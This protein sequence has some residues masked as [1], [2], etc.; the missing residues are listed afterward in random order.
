VILRHVLGSLLIFV[1]SVLPCVGQTRPNAMAAFSIAGSVRDDTGQH[2]M[3]NIRVDLKQATGIPVNT[4]FTRG[5]GRFEFAGLSNGEYVVE[6]VVKDYEPVQEKVTISGLGRRD[7]NIF[8]T[9]PKTEVDSNFGATISVHE[10]SVPSKAHEEYLKGLN[11]MYGKLDYTGAIVQFQR[12]IKDFPSFY[13]AYAQE[14]NAYLR[15]GE[16]ASAEESMR[17]SVNLSSGHYSKA[18][19]MLAAVLNETKRYSEAVTFARQGMAIDNG[20]WQGPLELAGALLGLQ[21]PEEAEKSAIQARDMKPDNPS[22]YLLLANILIYRRDY[23]ALLKD[24]DNYL[25]LVPSGPDADQAR[26]TRDD[27]QAALQKPENQVRAN[28]PLPTPENE[29]STLPG[30]DS[31][32]LPSLPPPGSNNQ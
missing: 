12:A 1:A 7:M 27:L 24:L 29:P 32:G 26:K 23:T 5:N 25:K 20:S 14:G 28:A 3:E 9:R 18:L 2:P 30:P 6:V 16:M 22:V 8:L 15:L 10:L 11:L 17:K 4:T 19:F 21:Q 31:S 13:E